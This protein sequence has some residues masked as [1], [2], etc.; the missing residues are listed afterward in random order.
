MSN[1]LRWL[2]ILKNPYIGLFRGW[3][4]TTYNL[5]S[6]NGTYS[7]WIANGRFSLDDD[8]IVQGRQRMLGGA[9]YIDK[10]L[11]WRAIKHDMRADG[12]GQ[13]KR[14]MEDMSG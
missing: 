2:R 11:I 9:S 1:I 12:I 5:I 3:R 10:S 4:K 6:P 7:L 8:N 14:F 13:L